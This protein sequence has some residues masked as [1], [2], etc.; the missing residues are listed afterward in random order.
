MYLFRGQ[1][2]ERFQDGKK[3]Y[4]IIIDMDEIMRSKYPFRLVQL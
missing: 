4:L 3:K 1:E 2:D